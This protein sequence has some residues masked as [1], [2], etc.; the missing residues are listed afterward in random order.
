VK[1]QVTVEEDRR[2]TAASG[3]LR[4]EV[5]QDHNH[6]HRIPGGRGVCMSRLD[7]SGSEAAAGGGMA[8]PPPSDARL[9]LKGKK[10]AGIRTRYWTRRTK[11]DALV[12][13]ALALPNIILIA[14]FTYRPLLANMY[15]STLDWTLGAPDAISVGLGNYIEFFTSSDASTV[16]GITAIFTVV[17]VGGAML[18]GLLVAVALNLKVRGRG[19][20]RA[21][22]FAPYVLSG[23]GVGLVWLFIFDPVYGVLSWVLRGF[24]AS[25]PQWINDPTLALWMV[26]IVYVWKNLGYCAVIYL[27][28]MQSIPSDLLEAASL[29]GSGSFR[30]FMSITLPLLSPTT[31]FILITSLLSSLQAFDII[32]IMTRTGNGTNTLI[33][34]A[35]LQA[36]STYNRA[37]YSAAI[38]VVL[39]VL[40][41]VVTGL[42][43]R[44]VERKVHYS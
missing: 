32:R 38:S 21:A 37:G 28:G 15:Y 35:Y 7:T 13:L 11:R 22:V 5:V 17:T 1:P 19:F 14:L 9:R 40:L 20:A 23:V 4:G 27:A 10:K 39:F 41:L 18:L 12:F 26:I 2:K 44:F 36:F 31:F 8:M 25:S 6:V 24:G 42:Q 3:F 33:F 16:L 29:D 34:E 43:L 30:R